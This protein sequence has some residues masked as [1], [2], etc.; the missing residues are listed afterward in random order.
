MGNVKKAFVDAAEA[1]K[2]FGEVFNGFSKGGFVNESTDVLSKDIQE[3]EEMKTPDL[4]EK[5]V[6]YIPI[7][8]GEGYYKMDCIV[9]EINYLCELY[10]K[11]SCITTGFEIKFR[12]VGEPEII[13][14]II[15][16]NIE[17]FSTIE[18]FDEIIKRTE[19]KEDSNITEII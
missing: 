1:M 8:K 2:R 5:A 15:V 6:A 3:A 13:E 7:Q 14:N 18:L 4:N 16:Q 9:E 11:T 10:S 17:Q 12:S 19:E